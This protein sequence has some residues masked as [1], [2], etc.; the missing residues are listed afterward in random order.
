VIMKR[1][2]LLSSMGSEAVLRNDL[3]GIWARD[4]AVLVAAGNRQEAYG[5]EQ[6]GL[7][8]PHSLDVSVS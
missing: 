6:C 7:L 4:R 1:C 8:V 3:D 2:Q 5:D